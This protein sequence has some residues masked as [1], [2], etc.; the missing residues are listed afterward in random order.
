MRYFA[1]VLVLL[2]SVQGSA[3]TIKVQN[4]SGEGER[5]VLVIVQNLDDHEREVMRVL[6]DQEGRLPAA[7]LSSGLY[8][9][10]ATAPYGTLQAKV[11]E[12]LVGSKPRSVVVRYN[13]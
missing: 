7:G 9:V 11:D 10:I 8:R 3:V 1:I 2:A 12:F 5:S 6:T 13:F 4:P